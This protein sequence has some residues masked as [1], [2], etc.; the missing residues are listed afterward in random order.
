MLTL[1]APK[2]SHLS[3]EDSL[4]AI[5][6]GSATKELTTGDLALVVTVTP[7]KSQPAA[8][9]TSGTSRNKGINF[10]TF[11]LPL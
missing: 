7:V 6:G 2:T 11:H 5:A 1:V 9:S 3:V 10:F 4:A 8:N